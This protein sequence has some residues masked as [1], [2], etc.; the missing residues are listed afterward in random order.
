MVKKLAMELK[1]P[2][3]NSNPN[4]CNILIRILHLMIIY[5]FKILKIELNEGLF[6]F[7]CVFFPCEVSIVLWN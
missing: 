1:N 4:G 6:K 5:F 3:P 2:N 7:D